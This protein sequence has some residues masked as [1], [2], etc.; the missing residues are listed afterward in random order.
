MIT[1]SARSGFDDDARVYAVLTGACGLLYTASYSLVAARNLA[2]GDRLSALFLM[3]GG[4]LAS[5]TFVA[6][7]R[8]VRTADEGYALWA[9]ILAQAGSLGA[10][11]HG[12]YNLA[13]TLRLANLGAVP[14][15][16]V[17]PRGLLTFG[18][19]GI[20]IL[21]NSVLLLQGSQVR[22]WVGYLGG[23]TGCL[24]V[25]VYGL[26]LLGLD[27]KYQALLVPALVAGVVG[28][29]WYVAMGTTAFAVSDVTIDTSPVGAPGL[30]ATV[31]R[32]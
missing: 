23:F 11:V 19:T 3:L 9:L 7:H 18:V 17:D 14:A 32:S 6:V 29:A 5:A 27:V 20:A 21:L 24:L 25:I 2:L 16:Q 13:L 15:S 12:G 30:A 10:A 28:P 31:E 22:R 26:H 4:F 1:G 8:L